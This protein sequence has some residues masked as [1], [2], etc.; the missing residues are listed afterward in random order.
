MGHLAGQKGSTLSALL[1]SAGVSAAIWGVA[2]TNI[3]SLGRANV[4]EPLN[5]TIVSSSADWP[6]VASAAAEAIAAD[7]FRAT[8]IDLPD[9]ALGLSS[10]ILS[11]DKEFRRLELAESVRYEV[12]RGALVRAY[13]ASTDVVMSGVK[14]V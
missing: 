10:I 6:D 13:G 2:L 8:W 3:V 11:W 14:S 5:P 7:L 9:G 12:T 4:E 1:V